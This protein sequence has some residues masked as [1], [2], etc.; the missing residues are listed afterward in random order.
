MLDES[1]GDLG[2]CILI[3]K[4]QPL[5]SSKLCF[6]SNMASKKLVSMLMSCLDVS[7][8]ELKL[9]VVAEYVIF[10]WSL[11][12]ATMQDGGKRERR[13]HVTLN[14]NPKFTIKE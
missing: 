7:F 9:I 11:I 12:G 8:K 10:P 2:L 6:K 4:D 3:S 5:T 1:E 13:N 14:P